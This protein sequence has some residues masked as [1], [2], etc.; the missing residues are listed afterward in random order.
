[1]AL[2]VTAGICEEVLFRGYLPWAL[3]PWLGW[4]G[5]VAFSTLSFGFAHSYQ[6][7]KGIIGS[8]T[9]GA[10]MMLLVAITRSL[11]PAMALHAVIDVTSGLL[12][13]IAFREEAPPAAVLS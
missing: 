2:S 13:W 7:R 5:A 6:G 9:I 8:L 11:L 3:T 4:W 12:G 10:L 1:M